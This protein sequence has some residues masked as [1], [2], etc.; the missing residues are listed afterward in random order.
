M[1]EEAAGKL[2]AE[3]VEEKVEEA[4]E[5]E[6]TREIVED[7]E[8]QEAEGPTD[9]SVEKPGDAEAV[10]EEAASDSARADEDTDADIEVE[11]SK[12]ESEAVGE[13]EDAS[14]KEAEAAP[15]PKAAQK[16]DQGATGREY[17]IEAAY[18]TL[19]QARAALAQTDYRDS[20]TLLKKALKTFESVKDESGLADTYFS[21]GVLAMLKGN[22]DNA[23]SHYRKAGKLYET[24]GQQAARADVIHQQG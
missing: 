14:E 20:Y 15:E 8:Q 12:V 2:E 17:E 3:E 19:A 18:E 21:M 13:T 11:A 7:E 10:S 24:L 5:V 16:D 6:K 1:S 9:K 4:K 22:Y 23:G